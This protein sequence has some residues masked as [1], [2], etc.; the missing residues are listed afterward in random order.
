[1]EKAS[2]STNTEKLLRKTFGATRIAYSKSDELVEESHY[3][4]G[5][6]ATASLGHWASRVLRS[7]KDPTGC[8]RWSYICLGKN[9]QKF[10]IVTV[11]RVGQNCNASN[12]TAFQ[13]QYRTQ[14]ADATARVEIN[15]N[16]QTR[17]EL[18]YFTEE[19][20][21][22]GFEVVFLLMQMKQFITDSMR[23]IMITST[24]PKRV[25]IFM[26]RSMVQSQHTSK[27]VD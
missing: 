13:Q 14:Y 24:S 2:L 15:P 16:R 20:K 7:G 27:T 4:P 17:I 25:S 8:R 10:S 26:V 11:Y 3:R 21:S 5:G 6:T 9:D 22:Y 19:L 23:R 18:G 12:A 1:M